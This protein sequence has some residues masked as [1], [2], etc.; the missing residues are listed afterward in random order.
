[1]GGIFS[2][3]ALAS[4]GANFKNCTFIV[5]GLLVKLVDLFA[6]GKRSVYQ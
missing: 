2:L 4:E 5:I 1:M 6:G 3:S